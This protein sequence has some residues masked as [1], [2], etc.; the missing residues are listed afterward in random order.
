MDLKPFDFA[1]PASRRP[2]AVHAG[3]GM[4]LN[5]LHLKRFLPWGLDHGN[6]NY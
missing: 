4:R 6:S 5:V 3:E 2:K 1:K